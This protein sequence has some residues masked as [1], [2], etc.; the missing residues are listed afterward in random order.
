MI[1]YSPHVLLAL[2]L[3]AGG[4]GPEPV[5]AG[6]LTLRACGLALTERAG[7]SPTDGARAIDALDRYSVNR[8][9]EFLRMLYSVAYAESRFRA[10]RSP[11]VPMRSEAGAVGM[12]Q[13]TLGAAEHI[14]V[15]RTAVGMRERA[16][17]LKILSQTPANVNYG[18]AYLHLAR[19]EAGAS[20]WVGALVMYNSGYKG[21]AR[22]RRGDRIPD[23]TAQYVVMIQHL[24]GTCGS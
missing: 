8:D 20:G 13:V 14:H 4:A 11:G 17:T 18:S 19:R 9:P 2:G 7:L 23:E 1:P 21:L 12:L 22:L 24:V 15:I 3:L 16:P 5:A 6:P 10:D